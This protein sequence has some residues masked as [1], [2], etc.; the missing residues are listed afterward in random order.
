MPDEVVYVL[1]TPGNSTV[2]IG[3]T[4][5][6][7]K[8]VA[9]IQ[10]MSPV[11]LDVLWTHP[12]G[13]ELE[14]RLHRHFADLRSHGEWFAFRTDPVGLIR[15]AVE[16]EP[17]LRPKVSLKKVPPMKT[18]LALRN[19]LP[20]L[21]YPQRPHIEERRK[22]VMRA[23]TAMPDLV[24]QYR[25]IERIQALLKEDFRR[26]RQEAVLELKHE[27]R[28]WRAVGEI[29]GVTGARAEQMSRGAR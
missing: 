2:K 16:D 6:L 8:R 21:I 11:P 22:D 29:I 17:W 12:G 7:A 28:S 1:G 24:E 23:I 9:E 15:W 19:P 5:N 14:T 26:M 18:P 20:Q 27:G 13:H 3:R 10:R 4:T 25:E